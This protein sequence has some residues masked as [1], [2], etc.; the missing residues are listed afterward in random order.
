MTLRL[1]FLLLPL[2]AWADLPQA[3]VTPAPGRYPSAVTVS[4]TVPD[5]AV[6]LYRFLESPGNRE[7]PWTGP[8]TLDALPGETRAYRLRL[9]TR[10]PSGEAVV[11]DFAYTV[12][13][14]A[15]KFPTVHP[16]P[17]TYT[18]P[19]TLAPALPDGW[20]L[21]QDGAVL[22][23]APVLDAPDGGRR[24]YVFEARG[25]GQ[26]AV[27][28]YDI[29]KRDQEPSLDVVS[30]VAGS[31]ANA[32]PLVLDF[33]GLD[34]VV[35]SYG[36]KLL[37]SALEYTGPVLLQTGAQTVTI[38]GRARDGRRIEKTVTWTSGA[39][40][41]PAGWPE[42]G[43]RTQAADFP[44]VAG[45]VS[46]DG[47][48]SWQTSSARREEAPALSRKVLVAEVQGQN[49][50]A[51]ARYVYW[52]DVRAPQAPALRFEGGWNPRLWFSGSP[53]AVHR[54]A[55]VGAESKETAVWGPVGSWKVPD[56]VTGARVTVTS[57]N[58]TTTEATLSFAETGWSVPRWEPWDQ[59]SGPRL[60]LGGRVVARPGFLAAYE[61]SSSPDVPEPGAASPWLDGAFLPAVP[62][63]ADRTFYVRFAWRDAA[64]LTG[65]A[66]AVY[67]V[68]VDRL[69][70]PLPTVQETDGT[71]TVAVDDD[72]KLYWAATPDRAATADSLTFQPYTG[73]I[74]R[75]S[76][77][78]SGLWFH[79]RAQDAAG[80]A[81]PAR[82]NVALTGT[83]TGVVQ[84]DPDPAVGETP[85]ADG[86]VYAWPE[87]RLRAETPGL[88]VAAA[89]ARTGLPP[90]WSAE[91]QPWTGVFVRSAQNARR[92][93]LVYWNLKTA[94]GWAWP[95]PKSLTLILDRGPPAAPDTSRWPSAPLAQS[96][97]L[98][99][100]PGQTG[101]SLRYSF[102]LDGSL[103]AD[104]MTS[105][106]PWPGTRSWEAPAGVLTTL[107]LRVA[108]V[109]VS[110]QSAETPMA[111]VQFDRRAAPPVSVPLEAY[112]YRNAPFTVPGPGGAVRFTLTTDGSTPTVPAPDSPLVG[113]GVELPGVAGQTVL[114]RLRWRAFS[115]AGEPGPAS[116][117][118]SVL[119][120]RTQSA[121]A[122]GGAVSGAGVTLTG[123]PPSGVSSSP[124][125]V[126]AQWTGPLRY[127]LQEGAGSP[128]P[129]T[130][131]SPLWDQ[132]LTLGADGVDR[133][134][135]LAVRGFTADGRPATDEQRCVVRVDRAAPGVPA[136]D[137]TAGATALA[138]LVRNAPD[139]D[140]TLEYRWVWTSYPTGQGATDWATATDVPVFSAP[141][142]AMTRLTARARLRDEAG[143]VGPEAEKTVF[144]DQNVVYVAPGKAGDGSRAAPAPSVAAAVDLARRS[145]R[146]VLFVAAGVYPVEHT[147][148][149]GGLSVYGGWASGQWETAP[150]AGRAVWT[151]TTGFSGTSLIQTA[152]ADW[153][154]TGVDLFA[155][156]G[157]AQV[158][159]VRGGSVTVRDTN[160]T[161]GRANQ[162]WRQE[163]GRLSLT[164][165]SAVYNAQPRGVFVSLDGVSASF[166]GLNL[167]AAGNQEA[168]L[169]SNRNTSA[170]VKDLVVVSKN[171]TGYD[172]VWLSDGGS[173][174]MGAARILAGE[175]AGRAL[176]FRLKNADARVSRLDLSLY[177]D[178]SN[179][180]FQL[181]GGTLNLDQS[182]VALLHGTEFNQGV[183]A[184]HADSALSAFTLKIDTGTYQGAF[185]LDGG[186]LTL[187]SGTVTVAG[188]GQQAWGGRFRGGSLVNIGDVA[189][190]L[191]QKTP[192]QPFILDVPWAD[193]SVNKSTV[194]GW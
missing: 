164:A 60:P 76:L 65:P 141:A 148:D 78:G 185:N 150:P 137:L 34:R 183:V 26:S 36:P 102:T 151:Q 142:G 139:P 62:W 97:T 54:V 13:R 113:D 49:P 107:R 94:D 88:W 5:G 184:D 167:A 109:S 38:S 108:A 130:S 9:T 158:V 17:G 84:V 136:F 103:P 135:T 25:P 15:S 125:V 16:V 68:R 140:D 157:L 24:T 74:A 91:L 187:S 143:N 193:G 191:S 138:T 145:G 79:A 174:T 159:S 134:Y 114:Y 59:G 64:G 153:T 156:Q 28:T 133:T 39:A 3:A 100:R 120:D 95:Q 89:D 7:L 86:G 179:T 92:S 160:W 80:N 96:W 67:A 186:S 122:A 14:P 93:F 50:G 152:G 77:G 83:A 155:A 47:G 20:T 35:W 110:G 177:S 162:G 180:A 173:V 117:T 190:T 69:P 171:G 128:R 57:V 182:A 192:G 126:A 132:P 175:G 8:L 127:E 51:A 1:L 56:G 2:A 37:D 168:F 161:W 170:T 73:P 176:A 43:V 42:S 172:G 61:V 63:G 169:F 30:P 98:T 101:D 19:V 144:L 27:W 70:P 90:T 119:I 11:R 112:T 33:R 55:W 105:G 29:D 181:T 58:G 188:G 85:V 115:D 81:G 21:T 116:D 41:A 87:F 166:D 124:V 22:A 44:V 46:W 118:Y 129:V 72:A 12:A 6:L 149:L 106:Q 194:N 10:Q 121:P 154:L 31:W 45:Q 147:L 82:L 71:I 32:Q 111:P 53:D 48:R 99:M 163:D 23:A 52:F 66:S 18:A 123:L 4:A 75:S 189:W 165:V 131:G 146:G 40:A 178:A 104:P